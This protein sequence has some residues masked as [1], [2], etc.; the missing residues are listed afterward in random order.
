MRFYWDDELPGF[1]LRAF[2]SG[3]RSYL[4]QYRDAGRTRRITIALHGVWTPE[5]ARREAE[6][7]LGRVAQ[8]EN[9]SE[10]KRLNA[11]S[12]TAKELCERSRRRRPRVDFG[13]RA[14]PEKGFD[15]RHRPE[16][17]DLRASA[18]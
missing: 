13:E 2:M 7:L 17:R 18:G 12:I 1:G 6:I 11:K 16:P 5:T 9:T 15:D 4:I 14:A 8:G 10:E 3:K